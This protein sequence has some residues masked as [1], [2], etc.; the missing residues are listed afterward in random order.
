MYVIG[1]DGGGTK[2]EAVVLGAD[3]KQLSALTGKA[4]N[5]HAVGFDTAM[6]HLTELLSEIWTNPAYGREFCIGIAIGL[7]GVDSPQEKQ[8]VLEAM[9]RFLQQ[10]SVKSTVSISNDAEIGLMATLGKQ[11]GLVVISGTGSIVYGI[12]PEGDKLRTGGWGHLLGDQG[13]GYAI[14]LQ[15][16][17]A[18]MQSHDGVYSQTR[19]TELILKEYG[20]LSPVELKSYIYAPVIKKQDIADFARFCIVSAEEHQ[21]EQAILILH[22]AAEELAMQTKA[23]IHKHPAFAS[24]DLVLSGSIFKHSCYMY[25]SFESQIRDTFPQLHIHMA[26]QTP[27]YGA[28]LLALAADPHN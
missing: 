20:F 13:S 10:Q 16:L 11:Q 25:K 18:V 2:T 14:G 22:L 15:T 23:L 8:K 5:P 1:I 24:G 4:T 12:T 7:A 19:M 28:A 21:D 3:G 26:R 6:Q 9:E 27:A 17:R